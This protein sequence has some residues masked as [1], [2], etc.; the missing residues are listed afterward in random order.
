MDMDMVFLLAFIFGSLF[1][2]TWCLFL[3]YC[4]YSRK[5]RHKEVDHGKLNIEMEH[6]LSG[7]NVGVQSVSAMSSGELEGGM[8]TY[9]A[10]TVP[11]STS[12]ES[13]GPPL[14]NLPRDTHVFEGNHNV[15]AGG[16]L[17]GDAFAEF[18]DD[19]EEEE[20]SIHELV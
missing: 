16:P 1:V 7:H 18:D 19:E 9:P 11:M 8:G 12:P 6:C 17:V 3:C 20:D 2:C 14:P 5:K 10:F 13:D 4:V 15:T